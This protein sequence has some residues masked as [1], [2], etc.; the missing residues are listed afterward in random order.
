[1]N[2]EAYYLRELDDLHRQ[3]AKEEAICE[4]LA[5]KIDG[6]QCNECEK[7]VEI[8]SL[9]QIDFDGEEARYDCPCG[10]HF[11]SEVVEA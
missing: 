2:V 10:D 4:K 11:W 5:V 1:M 7:I 9:D 8:E 3:E 6:T